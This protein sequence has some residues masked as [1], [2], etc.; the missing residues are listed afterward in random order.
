MKLKP[1]LVAI[2]VIILAIGL[3]FYFKP[4]YKPLS[5]VKGKPDTLLIIQ[6]VK[7]QAVVKP[8][9]KDKKLTLHDTVKTELGNI[10]I[11]SKDIEQLGINVNWD[12]IREKQQIT[13]VDTLRQTVSEPIYKNTWFWSTLVL[14]VGVLLALIK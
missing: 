1:I 10:Y 8:V 5:I 2:I 4:T 9:K 11:D 14:V 7:G 6:P 13:R 3:Y 12:L